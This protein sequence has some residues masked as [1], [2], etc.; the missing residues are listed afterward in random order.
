MMMGNMK[1][2]RWKLMNMIKREYLFIEVRVCQ[3]RM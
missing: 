1:E 2:K 3:K